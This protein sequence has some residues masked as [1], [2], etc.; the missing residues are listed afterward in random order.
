MWQLRRSLIELAP[1]IVAVILTVLTSVWPVI[2]PITV[3]IIVYCASFCLFWAY[4]V[5][6]LGENNPNWGKPDPQSGIRYRVIGKGRNTSLECNVED[7][8]NSPNARRHLESL[9]RNHPPL[10]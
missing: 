1:I 10:G 5:Q 8:L 4:F 2:K 7:I 3:P 9:R 6:E